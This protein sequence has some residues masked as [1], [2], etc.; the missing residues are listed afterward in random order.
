MSKI[1]IYK[2]GRISVRQMIETRDYSALYALSDREE[3]DLCYTHPRRHAALAEGTLVSTEVIEHPIYTPHPGRLVKI[4]TPR[5][6]EELACW[7]GPLTWPATAGFVDDPMACANF[8]ATW[9]GAPGPA[10]N[11]ED[12]R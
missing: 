7:A 11:I 9:L 8:L 10:L 6:A 12:Q 4:T 3:R 2:N 5:G 1:V